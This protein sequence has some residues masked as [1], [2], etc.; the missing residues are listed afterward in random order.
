MAIK[1]VEEYRDSELSR[2]LA[3]K[4]R[5]TSRR[6]IRLMEV[7]GT[8]TVSIFRHG[9]RALLPETVSLLSGPGCPVCVTD[10]AEIDT[11][12]ELSK[13]PEVAI[14]TFGDLMRVPGST[15]SLQRERAEGRD[16]RIVYSTMDALAVAQK[17]PDKQVI[18]GRG[19]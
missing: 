2:Q 6:R 19:L 15:S 12:I 3:E 16:I 8:H 5:R 4:I 7:C 13:Q 18:F 9:I 14:A 17:N 11:F 1:H 10:Q